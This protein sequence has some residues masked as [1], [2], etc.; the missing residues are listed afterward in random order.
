MITKEDMI[1]RQIITMRDGAR[2]LLRPLASIDKQALLDFFTNVPA[3]DLRYMRHNV[4]NIDL[5][6]SWVENIDYERVFPLVAV[7]GERIV[8]QGTLHFNEGPSRHR[9]EV[10]IYLSREIKHRGLGT[11]LIQA[12]IDIARKRNIYMMEV[13][14]VSD[15]IEVIKAFHKAGFETACTF[16]EYFMLPDGELRDTV[17]LILHLRK[18]EDEF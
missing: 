16:E 2:V 7:I 8:G 17:H 11:R 9:V 6:T 13:Q 3:E 4:H 14:V 5:I 12:L 1:Y 18:I 15:H 10:R